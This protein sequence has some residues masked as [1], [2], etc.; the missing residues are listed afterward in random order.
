MIA[1]GRWGPGSRTKFVGATAGAAPAEAAERAARGLA[2]DLRGR[3]QAS[4]LAVRRVPRVALHGA[5]AGG[6]RHDGEA[7]GGTGVG[8]DE[9]Q[10]RRVRDQPGVGAEL[11]A[12]GV[13]DLGRG[14]ERGGLGVTGPGERLLAQVRAPARA[15]VGPAHACVP[16]TVR[17][18]MRT[19]GR[20]TPTGTDCPSLPQVPMP[21]SS[22]RSA[23]TRVM[24]V[25][26]SGPLPMSVAPRTGRVTLPPSIRYASLAEKTNFPLVMS[27]CPPPK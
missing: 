26:T 20:P 8:A 18:S 7:R 27:T 23:P 6:H 12:L 22:R 25:S 9:A 21:S 19:V 3:L 16:P 2:P 17:P 15:P 11:G 1:S 10:A 24:R 13:G 14:G 4:E 5:V